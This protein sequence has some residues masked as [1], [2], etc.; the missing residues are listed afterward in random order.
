[1]AITVWLTGLP[2]SG[3]TTIATEL[4]PELESKGHHAIVLDGDQLR[5]GISADLGFSP[6]DRKAHVRRI[7]HLAELIRVQGIVPIVALISPYEADREFARSVCHGP[8]FEVWLQCPI[9]V[10]ENR[11]T[12]GV[13]A[14][15]RQGQ[16]E[17]VTGVDA[18][19]E[20]PRNPELRLSTHLRS[21]DVCVK[22]IMS[23]ISR[24]L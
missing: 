7:A 22:Q 2:S 9:S 21:A 19:Y 15:A 23:V 1:M 4:K 18:P 24:G 5:K 17:G 13:Y 20:E 6:R 16:L 8:F 3:K 14:K 11:D 12:H 10:C